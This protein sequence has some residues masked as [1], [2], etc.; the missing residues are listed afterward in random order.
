MPLKRKKDKTNNNLQI[1][2][3]QKHCL[4][5]IISMQNKQ[6]KSSVCGKPFPNFY[7]TIHEV[8]SMQW[9]GVTIFILKPTRE[10]FY[11]TKQQK[12]KG[13]PKEKKR[14]HH[15]GLNIEIKIRQKIC[16]RVN[17]Q[18]VNLQMLKNRNPFYLNHIGTPQ[19]KQ[20]LMSVV[21]FVS[22]DLKSITPKF[23]FVNLRKL[24]NIPCILSI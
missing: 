24:I 2:I 23:S 16:K 21:P 22:T 9:S 20:K 17:I 10:I 15:S 1:N 3:V 12:F 5:F 13:R 19:K 11:C 18:E 4:I 14:N 8:Y 6:S 7:V